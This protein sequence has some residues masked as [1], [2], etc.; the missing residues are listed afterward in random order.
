MP[1]EYAPVCVI[2]AGTMGRGIAQVAVASGHLVALVDPDQV[3]L[4]AAV[5]DITR[6]LA[7]KDQR[8]GQAVAERLT[9]ARAM[10]EVNPWPGTI[11]IEAVVE[12]LA[13]KHQVLGDAYRQLGES[14]VLATNTSSLSITE[15]AAGVP[16][17]AR[18]AG[19]HFFN[20]VPAMRLVEVVEGLQTDPAVLDVVDRLARSWGKHVARV[21]SAPGFIVNRVA[22]AFYG[23]ALRLVEE[24]AATPEVIDE[25]LRSAGFRMGPFELMDL[26]GVEVN[27]AVTR[28]V[29]EAFNFDPRFAPSPIQSELVAAGRLG[30]KSGH[31]FYPYGEN[32]ERPSARPIEAVGPVPRSVTLHGRD[33]QLESQCWRA[34]IAGEILIIDRDRWIKNK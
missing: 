11:A 15:I 20:P 19:M 6:R 25:V 5:D 31:G 17:P 10:S 9:T 23:E 1:E 26:I 21:R 29:W 22:R 13:V 4:D 34:G 30:R 7:K 32:A 33:R 18:V 27:L 12:S 2:G 28:T 14:C 24:R 8:L 3:Q 16:D